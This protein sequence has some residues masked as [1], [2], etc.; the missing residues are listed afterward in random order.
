MQAVLPTPCSL[1]TL[2]PPLE[3]EGEEDELKKKY[4]GVCVCVW[5]S[6][7]YRQEGEF[8]VLFGGGEEYEMG[9]SQKTKPKK[10]KKKKII[11]KLPIL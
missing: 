7:S 10:R 5:N 6:R 1:N 11:R 3:G 4:N 2:P 8:S 9:I